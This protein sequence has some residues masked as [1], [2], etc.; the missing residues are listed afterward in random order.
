MPS[1]AEC[2]LLTVVV[3]NAMN[4]LLYFFL[5]SEPDSYFP[6]LRYKNDAILILLK[7][8]LENLTDI[9]KTTFVDRFGFI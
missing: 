1:R 2:L 9:Y 5:K 6:V 7:L 3:W 8:V 4:N